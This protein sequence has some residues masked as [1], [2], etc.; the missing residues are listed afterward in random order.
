VPPSRGTLDACVMLFDSPSDPRDY[1]WRTTWFAEHKNES[2]LSLYA[3]NYEDEMVGPGI[4]LSVYGGALFLYPPVV[5]PDVWTD[6]RLDYTETLEERLLAAACIHSRGKQIAVLS[7]LP[8]GNGFRKLAR[9]YRKQLVHV[10]LNSFS[11]EQVQ[12]LRTVHVLNGSEVRSYA[13]EFIRKV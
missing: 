3:T 5:I 1:P 9:R 10:P 4:G 13:E 12:Q 6:A 2:T 7:A 8:P 11:D